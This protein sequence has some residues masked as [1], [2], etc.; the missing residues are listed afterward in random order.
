MNTL[1]R[2]TLFLALAAAAPLAAVHAQDYPSKPVTIVVGV[3]PGGSADLLARTTAE[4]LSKFLGTRV[5]VDNRPGA[6]SAIATRQVAR[7]PADGY[8][9]FYNASNMATNLVGMREPGYKW[10]DFE[11]LGGVASAPYVMFISTA[12]SKA[13]TL[14]EFVEFGKANPGKLTFASLG[15][16]SSP[17][18]V[19]ERFKDIT[20]IGYREVPYK[21]GAQAMGDVVGGTVD[22]YFPLA[23]AASA[24]VNQPN[25]AVLAVTGNKRSEQLPNV[26]TFAELGYPQMNDVLYGGLWV[27]AATPKPIL[28]KLRKAL[29]DTLKD[30][31]VIATMKKAG[32]TPYEGDPK[33]FDAEMRAVEAVA[34]EDYKKFKLDPQ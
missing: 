25:V 1:L 29:A 5:I 28:D 19:A 15:P 27:A 24:M 4:G 18:I 3:P 10:S 21:G 33:Q 7:A 20:G 34:R 17:G 23:N 9:L 12:S 11:S 16:G 32:Q 2:N 22:V 31:S 26:P 14:K 8:T 30:P 6:N 13:K